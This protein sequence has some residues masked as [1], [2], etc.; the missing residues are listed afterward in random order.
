GQVSWFSRNGHDFM[1]GANVS[2]IDSKI[3]LDADGQRIEGISSRD[4]QG[5]SPVLSNT[6][7]TWDHPATQ[8]T[9]T[10]SINYYDQRI[11]VAGGNGLQ[12]VYEKG[13]RI[14]NFTYEKKFLSGSAL[15]LKL[16]NLL[17]DDNVFVQRNTAN[18]K[19]I[20]ERW[21]TGVGA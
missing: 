21:R 6:R 11:D 2:Y 9:A 12:P 3:T 16:T 14:V 1:L 4:L 15:G 8:Q 18:T 7:F 19:S 13:R 5:Q 17:D 10:L 20:V